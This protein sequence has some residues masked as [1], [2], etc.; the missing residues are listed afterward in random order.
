MTKRSSEEIAGGT[1][2]R[3]NSKEELVDEDAKLHPRRLH[4]SLRELSSRNRVFNSARIK[5]IT[6]TL[7][8]SKKRERALE[9]MAHVHCSESLKCLISILDWELLID[10][11]AKYVKALE[12]VQIYIGDGDDALCLPDHLKRR[13]V[14]SLGNPAELIDHLE[15]IKKLVLNDLR[16]NSTLLSALNST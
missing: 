2:K 14:E 1:F 12:L 16:F 3:I 5:D 8:D 6:L 15:E 11:E 4:A 10:A 9:A 13:I 7:Q